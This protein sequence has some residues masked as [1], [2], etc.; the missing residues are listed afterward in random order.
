MLPKQKKSTRWLV[1][2][3]IFSIAAIAVLIL[4]L[5]SANAK[6]DDSQT[7]YPYIAKRLFQDDP[8]D[9]LINFMDL[10]T[11]L[12]EY[13]AKSPEKI[14][15]YFEYLPTGVNIN[16]GANDEF[17]RASLAKL[18]AI[19]RTYKL[20]EQDLLS[21][22]DILTVEEKQ[23][24]SNFG[25]LWKKGAGTKL[26]IRELIELVL[27]KSD[28][29]AFNVIYERVNM[30]LLKDSPDGDQS[31][32]DVYDYLDIPRNT[33]G[34]TSMIT[35][36]NF[37]SMLKSLY[38]SA[39]LSYAHSN[40]ILDTMAKPHAEEWASREA[41]ESIRVA[42]KIGAY[43]IEPKEMQVHSDCGI[44]YYP[45]RQYLLCVMVNSPDTD[46]SVEHIRA[47]SKIVYTFID[48]R[49]QR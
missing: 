43:N 44:F 30:Q 18:P 13:T 15:L 20:E 12:Q 47:I 21:L 1:Y 3:Q 5:I 31:I 45:K 46:A 2:T 36:K 40:E 6:Q 4:M 38:F 9:I 48:E 23:L 11:S 41:P 16:V 26:S 10:R 34:T 17:F 25:D 35:P 27:T 42:D 19:M 22:D 49:K 8:N 32:D 28:N 37:S 14:G 33:N 29:T 24:D 39:Y 7:K